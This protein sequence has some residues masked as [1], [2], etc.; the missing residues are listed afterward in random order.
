MKR[1]AANN[2]AI[3]ICPVPSKK[4]MKLE[5]CSTPPHLM[6]QER[7]DNCIMVSIINTMLS[8]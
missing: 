7:L 3:S 2:T 6:T 5:D 1:R 4:Q 8:S